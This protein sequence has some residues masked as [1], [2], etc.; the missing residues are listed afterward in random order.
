MIK[1]L[2]FL[3]LMTSC[4]SY[5][6]NWTNWK[7]IS[8]PSE[9]KEWRFCRLELDGPTLNEKGLC[10]Q[11]QECRTRKRILRKKEIQCR[12][13]TLFCKWGDISCLKKYNIFFSIIINKG[14][15]R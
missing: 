4:A 9:K 2:M 10:F 12:N 5:S 8:V 15:R 6:S 3:L 11:D 13:K 14:V 7:V 1:I